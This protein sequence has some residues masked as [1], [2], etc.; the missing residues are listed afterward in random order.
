MD[1]SFPSTNMVV[2]EVLKQWPETVPVFHYFKT[3]CVGCSM[4]PFDTLEDVARIYD[5]E[6]SAF[7]AALN[8]VI[9]GEDDEAR[10]IAR[11]ALAASDRA[12]SEHTP[13]NENTL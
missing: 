4:A 9:D 7:M 3:A 6:L 10:A 12:P 11:K 1:K 13:F 5:L 2:E 8:H